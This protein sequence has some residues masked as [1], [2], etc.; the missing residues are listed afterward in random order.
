MLASGNVKR[1]TGIIREHQRWRTTECLNL[2]PSENRGSEIM[3]SMYESD[4]GN[5]YSAP[6]NFYRGT[7]YVDEL[8]ALVGELAGRVFKA[9]H[10]DVRPISGHV[11]SLAVLLSMTKTGDKIVSLSE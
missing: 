6:D 3:R 9:K 4:L 8:I 11:A 7:R 5:R 1:L 2:I 10:A